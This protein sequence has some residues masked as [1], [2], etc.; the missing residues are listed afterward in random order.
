MQAMTL[1]EWAQRAC[2]GINRTSTS[3]TRHVFATEYV[4]GFADLW[5]LDDFVVS[6]RSGPIVW[7]VPK[8]AEQVA[9]EADQARYERDWVATQIDMHIGTLD[10]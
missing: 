2:V 8:S 3:E 6:T 10:A 9:W 4:T 5:H 7:L 1:Q